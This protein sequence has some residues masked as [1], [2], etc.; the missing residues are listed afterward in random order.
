MS[1]KVL[2]SEKVLKPKFNII[3]ENSLGKIFEIWIW[4]D[5]RIYIKRIE[6]RGK[7]RPI[8]E[9][10]D[11]LKQIEDVVENYRTKIKR[12]IEQISIFYNVEP[13]EK[14]SS[15]TIAKFIDDKI[16]YRV[17]THSTDI[18]DTEVVLTIDG[19][20]LRKDIEE[21]N[22]KFK[23][24]SK[25]IEKIVKEYIQLKNEFYKI[26]KEFL[27]KIGKDDTRIYIR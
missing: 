21:A 27:K 10:T 3:A 25:D 23:C 13:D 15:E 8:Y 14:W 11:Y 12:I 24:I 9:V 2:V 20:I 18:K 6:K 19:T 22:K 17:V 26:T 4:D 5:V 1:A 7:I 16:E